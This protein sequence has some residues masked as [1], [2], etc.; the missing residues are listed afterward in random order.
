MLV[1]DFSL[2]VLDEGFFPDLEPVCFSSRG[3]ANC[4]RPDWQTL[5]S[6][7]D[8]GLDL[9]DVIEHEFGYRSSFRFAKGDLGLCLIELVEEATVGR[10]RVLNVGVF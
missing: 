4:L 10:S 3:E 2:D 9:G 5:V 8:S 1:L 7:C 6:D